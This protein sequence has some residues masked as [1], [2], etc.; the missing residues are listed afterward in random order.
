MIHPSYLELMNTINEEEGENYEKVESRY[1]IV[2][3]AAKRARQLTDGAPARM[4]VTVNKVLSTAV[5]ELY[6]GKVHLIKPESDMVS[7]E[8][9]AETAETEE[10]TEA[11]EE[12]AEDIAE[13]A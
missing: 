9:T 10:A 13:E 6:N 5:S 7:E 3:A 11:S 8:E 1:S 2:I 4:P 12:T